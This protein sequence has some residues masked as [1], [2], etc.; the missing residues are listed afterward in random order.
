MKMLLVGMG[1]HLYEDEIKKEFVRQ[2]CFVDF[3]LDA[4]HAILRTGRCLGKRIHETLLKAYQ[5]QLLQQIVN[6]DYDFVL[7]IVGRYLSREFLEQLKKLKPDMRLILYLWDDVNRVRNFKEVR[8]CYDVIY[9][10]ND[11]D[12]QTYHLKFLPLFYLNRYVMHGHTQRPATYELFSAMT[13]YSD[14]YDVVKSILK[15]NPNLSMKIFFATGNLKYIRRNIHFWDVRSLKAKGICFSR[16]DIRSDKLLRGIK[17]AKALLDIPFLGQEGLTIRTMESIAA[18]KKLITT[19]ENVKKY[20]LYH[21]DNVLVIHRS[22][23]VIDQEWLQRPFKKLDRSVYDK[24]S[25]SQWTQCILSGTQL[26]YF[27]N[28]ITD[29]S[30]SNKG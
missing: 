3:C 22:H 4:T 28:T 12:V 29:N 9:S 30:V 20:D 2:G 1:F 24:Y 16:T 25:V 8:S 23:P 15:S 10:F 18:N 6:K 5:N 21:P 7:V 19:N 26:N 14:R 17:N 27:R 11:V 13:D